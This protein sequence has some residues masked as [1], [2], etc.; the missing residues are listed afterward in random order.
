[1]R[2]R[3]EEDGYS[4]EAGGMS[5]MEVVAGIVE[6]VS[7][8]DRSRRERAGCS[9]AF[10]TWV[11]GLGSCFCAVSEQSRLA[12]EQSGADQSATE[13]AGTEQSRLSVRLNLRSDRPRLAA[14]L[15]HA[16]RVAVF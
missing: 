2:G 3:D 6:M 1:M 4:R 8:V 15:S 16:R 14:R 12:T 7:G 9:A 11:L 13:Q 5:R 10:W